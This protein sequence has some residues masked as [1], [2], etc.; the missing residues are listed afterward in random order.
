MMNCVILLNLYDQT[1][2]FLP[3]KEFKYHI[4]YYKKLYNNQMLYVNIREMR[5]WKIIWIIVNENR[6]CQMLYLSRD[7]HGDNLAE[8][9]VAEA[10]EAWYLTAR[11]VAASLRHHADPSLGVLRLESVDVVDVRWLG[12]DLKV[13]YYTISLNIQT[14]VHFF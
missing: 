7:S 11:H 4:S 12:S 5:W 9:G 2:I 8:S 3:F 14:I 6:E 10:V 13:T 1:D